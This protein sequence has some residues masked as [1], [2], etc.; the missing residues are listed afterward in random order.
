M[1]PCTRKPRGLLSND[2]HD[3]LCIV[4][5]TCSLWIFTALHQTWAGCESAPLSQ[6]ISVVAWSQ[7][8]QHA[9]SCVLLTFNC[10]I[11]SIL[12][13]NK[14]VGLRG[15]WR[16]TIPTL[17]PYS[18]YLLF[19]EAFPIQMIEL[20]NTDM[21]IHWIFLEKLNYIHYLSAQAGWGW[22]RQ[23]SALDWIRKRFSGKVSI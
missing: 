18:W 11:T 9:I 14:H 4:S 17:A 16:I 3:D 2:L 21:D 5:E 22:Q 12:D 20:N 6:E 13:Y 7:I 15:R 8:I 1:P 19:L 10:A 23:D